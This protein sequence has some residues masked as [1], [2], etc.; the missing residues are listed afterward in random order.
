MV[1]VPPDREMVERSTRR[2]HGRIFPSA[3]LDTP[4]SIRRDVGTRATTQEPFTAGMK[5]GKRSLWLPAVV[6]WLCGRSGPGVCRCLAVG[7]GLRVPPLL[8]ASFVVAWSFPSP[9]VF[10][11][12]D[13]W[14][15]GADPRTA[16]SWVGMSGASVRQAGAWCGGA[17]M[18]DCMGLVEICL[19]VVLSILLLVAYS[20]RVPFSLCHH[21][22]ISWKYQC[23]TFDT[24]RSTRRHKEAVANCRQ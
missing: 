5:R 10:S 17:G 8:C 24:S 3:S 20:I 2:L 7:P 13:F 23:G 19:F 6:L 11:R 12:G 18:G 21:E 22:G 9:L 16:R 15:T 14:W 1:E 4:E